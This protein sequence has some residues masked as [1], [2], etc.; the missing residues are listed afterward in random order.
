[1]PP[2]PRTVRCEDCGLTRNYPGSAEAQMRV[3][4]LFRNR[5]VNVITVT[6]ETTIS[7]ATRLLM[8]HGIGALPVIT[9]TGS[10]VGLVSERDIVQAVDRSPESVGSV[11][12]Q[13]VMRRPAPVCSADT[14]INDVMQSMTRERQRH[15]VVLDGG[16]I[17]GVVS[18]GDMV[19]YRVEQLELETG[20]LRDYVAAQRASS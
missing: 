12:V 20:V 18:V 11:P 5:R 4:E 10:V 17:A 13:Q 6:P 19:K 14:P 16:S 7:G 2:L 8:Q 15:L 3:R 9:A 1:M